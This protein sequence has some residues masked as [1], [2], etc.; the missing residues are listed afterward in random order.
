MK[1]ER[2]VRVA[3]F[4]LQQALDSHSDLTLPKSASHHLVTV[5]RNKPGDVIDLFNGDGYNYRATII[6]TGQRTPGKQ[7]QLRIQ[8]R[9]AILAESR[10]AITLIQAISRGDR[11]DMTLRQSVELG[12]TKIQPLYSR[13]SAKSLDDKRGKKKMEH[14]HNIIVSACEQSGRAIVPELIA[15]ML[16]DEWIVSQEDGQALNL[17]LSP[18]AEYSLTEQLLQTKPAPQSIGLMVGPESGFD[19]HEIETVCSA[20][21]KAARIGPRVLR[22]ETAGP[23]CITLVQSTIGDMR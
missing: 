8:E 16:L 21:V 13:H 12:V 2:S 10:I 11:M 20:G 18:T 9:T 3:R 15:P 4:Y 17:I 22:T 6:A 1:S 5:L 14:W 19:T 7:A 23:A